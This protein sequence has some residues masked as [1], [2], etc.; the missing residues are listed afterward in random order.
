VIALGSA[1]QAKKNGYC[2]IYISNESDDMVYFDNFTLKHERGQILEETHYYPFGL[3][4]SGISSKAAGK[5]ENKFKLTGKELQSKEFSDGSGLEEYDYGARFYDPQIGRWHTL[6]PLADKF[7]SIS[8]Y[9]FS[10]NNPMNKVDPDGRAASPIYDEN[11][12][13]LGTDQGGRMKM[14]I[15]F[16]IK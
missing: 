10:E 6:D 7:I 9:N 2:Y 14:S 3:T 4:M 1:R 12:A 13:L 11:G 16:C 15:F 8:P 5:L